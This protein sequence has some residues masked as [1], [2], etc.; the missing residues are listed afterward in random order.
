MRDWKLK[1]LLKIYQH[2]IITII[3]IANKRKDQQL[4]KI[5]KMK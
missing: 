2:I 5:A 4:M 3:S 1:R